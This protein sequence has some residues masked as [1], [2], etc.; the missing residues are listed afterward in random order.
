MEV[1]ACTV[2]VLRP[3]DDIFRKR[4]VKGQEGMKGFRGRKVRR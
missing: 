2:G 4:I 3:W 1:A